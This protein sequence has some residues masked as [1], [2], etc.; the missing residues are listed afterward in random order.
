MVAGVWLDRAG[1]ARDE[2]WELP[3]VAG[4]E[5]WELLELSPD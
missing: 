1:V 5:S 2:S 4:D 3:E